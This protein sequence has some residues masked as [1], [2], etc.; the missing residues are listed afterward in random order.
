MPITDIT[1]QFENVNAYD[2]I[3]RSESGYTVKVRTEDISAFPA[4]LSFRITGSWADDVTGQ[5]RPFGAGWFIVD[6]HEVA[7]RSDS[8][9]HLADRLQ[10]GRNLMVGRVELA[11]INYAARL[12]LGGIKPKADPNLP[13]PP[14]LPMT[15]DPVAL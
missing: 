9:D 7:I 2:R 15:G 14:D 3:Y 4:M 13:Q 6:P 5:A 12:A 11:A 1:D 8:L 10:A